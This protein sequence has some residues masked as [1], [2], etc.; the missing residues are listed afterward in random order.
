MYQ[1]T[2]HKLYFYD[3]NILEQYIQ[4]KYH[5]T[6]MGGLLGKRIC[7]SFFDIQMYQDT[8]GIV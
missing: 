7:Y 1:D 5:L 3:S 2:S 4:Y 8:I 6:N